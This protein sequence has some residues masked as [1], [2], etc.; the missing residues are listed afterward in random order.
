MDANLGWKGPRSYVATVPQIFDLW[1]DPQ[2][3]YDL[4]MNNFTEKTWFLPTV[5]DLTREFMK[6]YVKDPPRKQQSDG[7]TGPITLPDY[8]RFKVVRDALEKQG[9]SVG[10]PGGN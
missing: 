5:Q 9:F 3:R 1:A 4:F 2:E 8:E 6:T 7:Y 10:T